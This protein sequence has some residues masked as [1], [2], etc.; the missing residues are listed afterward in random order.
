M[1][2]HTS[3]SQYSQRGITLTE[4][5]LVLAVAAALAVAA[6]AAYSVAR[7][8]SRLSELASGTVTMVEMIKQVWSLSGDYSEVTAEN[9]S[10]AGILPKPYKFDGNDI[11]DPFGNTVTINGSTTSFAFAF[12]NL[13]N[14]NCSKLAPT[15]ASFAYQITVGTD[16][17]A[18]QGR[19]TGNLPYKNSAGEIATHHLITACGNSNASQRNIAVEIR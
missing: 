10:K 1:Q 5:L 17:R 6:Y 13:S 4:T 3:S 14:E 9:I 12:R 16:A 18:T 19:V 11:Q 2:L 7:N 15:L 8:D